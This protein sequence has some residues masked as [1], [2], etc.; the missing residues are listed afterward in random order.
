MACRVT[1]P[2]AEPAWAPRDISSTV[3]K[4]A[5]CHCGTVSGG[6]SVLS[7]GFSLSRVCCLLFGRRV[8]FSAPELGFPAHHRVKR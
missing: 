8:P 6:T 2:A 3:E 1:E 4:T 5:R 7:R